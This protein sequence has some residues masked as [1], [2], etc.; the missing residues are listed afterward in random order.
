MNTKILQTLVLMLWSIGAVQAVEFVNADNSI[1][2]EICIA[3]TVS[4]QAL[5]AKAKEYKY[6]N[7]QVSQFSCNGLPIDKFAKKYRKSMDASQ[8]KVFSFDN[9]TG[10]IEAE[11][12]IAAAHSS[13]KFY[14]VK[15]ELNRPKSYY[16]SI[17]CNDVP[18]VK[19]ARKYG[20]KHFKI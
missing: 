4:D 10:S 8:V 15:A 9:T 13:D 7:I 11:L 5:K 6:S 3:A 2:T 14:A 1:N 19:F 20:N 16:E 12:C 17:T 18:L